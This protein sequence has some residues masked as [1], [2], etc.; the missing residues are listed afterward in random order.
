MSGAKDK[1]DLISLVEKSI[2]HLRQHADCI[3]DTGDMASLERKILRKLNDSPDE[4]SSLFV[5]VEY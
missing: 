1:F 2:Q 5:Q 4:V 3:T